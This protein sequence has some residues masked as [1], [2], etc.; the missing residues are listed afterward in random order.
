MPRV[1]NLRLEKIDLTLIGIFYSDGIFYPFNWNLIEGVKDLEYTTGTGSSHFARIFDLKNKGS[2]VSFGSDR[3]LEVLAELGGTITRSFLDKEFLNRL[4]GGFFEIIFWNENK[5]SKFS[6]YT[7]IISFL[8][9]ISGPFVNCNNI[10]YTKPRIVLKPIYKDDILY[11][12][13]EA[14]F[15]QNK[16]DSK[17]VFWSI[18]PI[19]GKN[20][21]KQCETSFSEQ[22]FDKNSSVIISN[23]ISI[24]NGFCGETCYSLVNRSPHVQFVNGN[25]YYSEYYLNSLKHLISKHKNIKVSDFDMIQSTAFLK[26]F[27]F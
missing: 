3:K 15:A 22:S 9:K 23:Y 17:G 11:L 10:Y 5:F 24:V 27:P 14:P 4:Y 19:I 25:T 12:Y 21:S 16:E 8:T 7:L 18:P 1:E 2:V 20:S 26:A 6:D 13:R